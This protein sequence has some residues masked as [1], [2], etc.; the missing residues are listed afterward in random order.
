MG[1]GLNDIS[2]S[3]LG[4]FMKNLVNAIAVFMERSDRGYRNSGP[5]DDPGIPVNIPIAS[6]LA[7]L[8][9]G[10]VHDGPSLLGHTG[11]QVTQIDRKDVLTVHT[12]PVFLRR[13]PKDEI[14]VDYPE[15]EFRPGRLVELTEIGARTA[16]LTER[17]VEVSAQFG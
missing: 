1:N 10:A 13:I 5:G 14:L 4:I 3:Q 2:M 17:H 16:E 12:H 7:N 11:R 8:V 15:P 9:R 6:D